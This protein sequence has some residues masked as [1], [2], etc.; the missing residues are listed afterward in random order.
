V[1]TDWTGD[2]R[3]WLAS[4]DILAAPAPIHARLRTLVEPALEAPGA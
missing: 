2:D 1:V 4:G 3:V